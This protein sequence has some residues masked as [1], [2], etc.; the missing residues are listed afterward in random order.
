MKFVYHS[1]SGVP[2]FR[3]NNLTFQPSS[4][5][6]KSVLNHLNQEK[7]G[8]SERQPLN[9]KNKADPGNLGES[10][11]PVYQSCKRRQLSRN[12]EVFWM[13]HWRPA[14]GQYW[15]A[16]NCWVQTIDQSDPGLMANRRAD[17]NLRQSCVG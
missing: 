10:L 14:F 2:S 3:S 6:E 15:A 8:E 16:V 4:N 9:D 17:Q 13:R 11:N 1:C 5:L 7:E 12:S